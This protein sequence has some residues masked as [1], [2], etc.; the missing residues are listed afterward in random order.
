M[1]VSDTE[2]TRMYRST[3]SLRR[4]LSTVYGSDYEY[5]RLCLFPTSN[6]N[7]CA[8]SSE[9]YAFRWYD[10]VDGVGSRERRQR[11]N[12]SNVRLSRICLICYISLAKASTLSELESEA[13]A[14][15]AA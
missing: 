3:L 2:I 6:H 10:D 5:F 9:Y 11:K 8:N 7:K 15:A 14:A 12:L 1:H 4:R 13:A